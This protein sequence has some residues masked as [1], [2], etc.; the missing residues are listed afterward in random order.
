[1]QKV[2][3]PHLAKYIPHPGKGGGR[4]EVGG[5]VGWSLPALE[6]RGLGRALNLAAPWHAP[7]F[8]RFV[9]HAEG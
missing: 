7:W 4:R 8:V 2:L 1:M 5:P 9:T 3:L 6:A